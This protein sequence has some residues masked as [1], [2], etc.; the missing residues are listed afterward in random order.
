MKLK[1]SFILVATALIA[2]SS[3]LSC[4]KEQPSDISS[5]EHERI[6]DEDPGDPSA[7]FCNIRLND[8][9]VLLSKIGPISIMT[10]I[11]PCVRFSHYLDIPCI[12][13]AILINDSS[14]FLSY[15]NDSVECVPFVNFK[16]HSI[17]IVYGKVLG[18]G[19]V[20]F[21]VSYENK[22]NNPTVLI[23]Y[24]PIITDGTPWGC[25]VCLRVPKLA[26]GT[27]IKTVVAPCY[28]MDDS[29]YINYN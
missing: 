26:Q 20:W 19:M 8:S 9:V 10:E 21:Q 5:H 22:Q 23:P 15:L 6:V 12:N 11:S 29:I 13:T 3:I 27:H 17:I 16:K 28:N 1:I 24:E 4:E 7:C 25:Y 2:I 18:G 14:T